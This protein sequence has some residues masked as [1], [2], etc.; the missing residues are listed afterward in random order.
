MKHNPVF[1]EGLKKVR[2]CIA[3]KNSKVVSTYQGQSVP[4]TYTD[5]ITLA[6]YM[7]DTERGIGCF[8]D[9]LKRVNDEAPIDCLN[10]AYPG[11]HYA[12]LTIAWWSRLKRPGKE[13]PPDAVWQVEEI[14]R[15]LDTDYELIAKEGPGPVTARIFPQII[16]QVEIEHFHRFNGPDFPKTMQRYVDAGYPV[17]SSGIVVPPFETLCGGRSMGFFFLDCYKKIDSIKAAQD[18]MMPGLFEDINAIEMDDYIIG[19]WI[20]GWR[21]ASNMINKKIW[22]T[23][24]WP[25][26]KELALCLLK[27]GITPILHLDSCWDRDLEHLLELPAKTCIVN[28]DGTTDIR[29]ARKVL[30]DHMAIMGDVPSQILTVLSREEII[31]YCKRLINDIGSQG[32]FLTAGCDA[33]TRSKYENIVAIHEAA[34]DC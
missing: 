7:N 6:E 1:D 33:P 11:A 14:N 4:A 8:L 10:Q 13:L 22:D 2:D 5:G 12:A 16:D 26:M 27:K 24:V 31:D 15:M 32:L 23:L 18:A 25:Y 29:L 34:R 17:L 3:F 30:G 9:F 28:F 20:G 19:R 21:G